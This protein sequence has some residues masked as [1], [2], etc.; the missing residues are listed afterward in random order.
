MKY[1]SKHWRHMLLAP[2]AF[3]LAYPFCFLLLLLQLAY[4]RQANRYGVLILL[5]LEFPMQPCLT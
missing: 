4:L 1:S 5:A 3:E 2:M